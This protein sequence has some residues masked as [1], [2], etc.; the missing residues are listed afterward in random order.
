VIDFIN[1]KL[2]DMFAPGWDLPKPAIPYR[3]N[4]DGIPYTT[5]EDII[6]SDAF[7]KQLKLSRESRANG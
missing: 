7:K 1:K 2:K 3:I 4:R 6:N 5:Y